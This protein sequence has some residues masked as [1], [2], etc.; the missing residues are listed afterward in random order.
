MKKRSCYLWD[1]QHSQVFE[2]HLVQA[3]WE[4]TQRTRNTD[5]FQVL[6]HV[7]IYIR[8]YVNKDKI[9]K[10]HVTQKTQA[11]TGSGVMNNSCQ[12]AHK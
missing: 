5:S 1:D 11:P 9:L 6:T 2:C 12:N 4:S 10:P 3:S 7:S 8:T